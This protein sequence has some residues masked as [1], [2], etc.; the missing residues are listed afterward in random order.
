MDISKQSEIV[1]ELEEGSKDHEIGVGHKPTILEE[2]A[3]ADVEHEEVPCNDE[4]RGRKYPGRERKTPA[5]LRDYDTNFEDDQA[6]IN[7]DYCYYAAFPKSY[8]EAIE[9]PDAALWEEAIKEDSLVEIFSR[10]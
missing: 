3:E 4:N 7:I 2:R 10:K 6:M 1:P 8:K 5:Y 9:S